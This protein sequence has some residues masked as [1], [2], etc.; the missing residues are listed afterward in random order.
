MYLELNEILELC[1]RYENI[2]LS[3]EDNLMVKYITF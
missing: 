1:K 3:F 2:A